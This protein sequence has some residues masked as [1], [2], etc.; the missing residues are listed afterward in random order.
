MKPNPSRT[1]WTYFVGNANGRGLIRIEVEDTGEHITSMP[2]GAA[3]EANA[4]HIVR[5]VNAHPRLVAAL[6][7]FARYA[8]RYVLSEAETEIANQAR[9]ALKDL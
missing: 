5:C 7:R 8:D 4:A 3:D 2:R 6:E 1:P 9:E